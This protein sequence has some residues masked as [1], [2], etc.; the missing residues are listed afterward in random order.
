[1][2]VIQILPL[3]LKNKI[4]AGE[5]VERP[6]SVVK[7]LLENAIDAGSTQVEVTVERGGSKLIR[8]ADDGAGMDEEDARLA[9]QRHAT[10]KLCS[11]RDLFSITTMGFRGEALPSIASVSRMTLLSAPRGES[12]GVRIALEGGEVTED[13]GAAAR[14]TTVEVRD[15]F[16]NTPARKK[17]LKRESTELMHV[18]DTVTNLA[19]SHPEIGVTLTVDSQES[20]RL[21]RASGVRERIAQVYGSEFLEDLV[22]GSLE[23]EGFACTALVSVPGNFRERRTHQLVFINKRPVRNPSV[24][25]AVYS[26]YEGILPRDKHPVFFLFLRVEPSRVDFNVHPAKR[27]AKFA[28]G[29]AVYRRVRRCVS[30][31]VRMTPFPGEETPHAV[32]PEADAHTSPRSFY[33]RDVP[34]PSEAAASAA[35]HGISEALEL[36]YRAEVPHLYLGETFVALAQGGGL[37]L[38]DHH[39]AHERVLYEKFLRGIDLESRRLLFPRQ[40]KLSRKE[41]MLILENREFL[42]KFGLEVDDFGRDTVIVRALPAALEE[43]DLRGIL[44][45]AAGALQEGERPGKSLKEAVAARLACHSSVRGRTVLTRESLQALLSDLARAE[46]PEHC[47]HGR[48]TRL[49]YSMDELKKL[50]KRM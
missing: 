10:S 24:S 16:F 42:H 3:E 7:E 6:A 33:P 40:V 8:V 49:F 17:F 25:H 41:H 15:L 14:G 22:E 29:E 30:E 27:E 34:F 38:L 45:D 9:I 35:T 37:T 1:M 18:V 28:D 20:M 11:E 19:L 39:A 32:A 12:L 46:D 5:V 26:A 23:D 4:A 21:P 44:A 2:P 13:A 36:D 48:P 50:F 47:P 31:A 43:A